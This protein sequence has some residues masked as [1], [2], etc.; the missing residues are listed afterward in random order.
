MGV[1]HSFGGT[2]DEGEKERWDA[3]W[4]IIMAQSERKMLRRER[5]WPIL[6]GGMRDE[7]K[8]IPGYGRYAENCDFNQVGSR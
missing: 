1:Q 3:G 6:T 2:R 8:K 5:D 4:Q 7:N